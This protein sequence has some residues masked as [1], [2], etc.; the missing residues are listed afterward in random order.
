MPFLSGIWAKLAAAGAIVLGLLILV[1]KLMAAGR[2]RE[3]AA[4]AKRE[5]EARRK[6]DEVERRVD[7]AGPAERERLRDKWTR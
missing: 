1:G 4:Q 5:F 6:G 7:A 3:K 2:D